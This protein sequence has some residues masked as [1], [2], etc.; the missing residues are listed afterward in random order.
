MTKVLKILGDSFK[1]Y[2]ASGTNTFVDNGIINK[3]SADNIKE[4]ISNFAN[5]KLK[6]FVYNKH[7]SDMSEEREP[8]GEVLS[9]SAC[10]DSV[11]LLANIYFNDNGE[12]LLKKGG[13]YPSIEMSGILESFNDNIRTWSNCML[14]ALACVEYPASSNV[15]LLCMSGVIE[16]QNN[17]EL[18][19][20][21]NKLEEL[22]QQVASGNKDVLPELLELLKQDDT[23]LGEIVMKAVTPT[24]TAEPT[25]QTTETETTKVEENPDGTVTETKT[26]VTEPT[27]EEK[28]K[29]EEQSLSMTEWKNACTKYAQR[30]GAIEVAMSGVENT[31]NRAKRMYK[32][33]E[34]I[35]N[36]IDYFKSNFSLLGEVRK[37]KA[38]IDLSAI[39]DDEIYERIGASIR[40]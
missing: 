38:N 4:L 9:L 5:N 19:N 18:E 11:G 39:K 13:F 23:L 17:K 26:E 8:I 30:N 3:I 28:K 15:D 21:D 32:S 20:M 36:I 6:V 37:E 10:D 24:A 22:M 12:K 7:K 34:S 40:R 33:G 1:H 25:T 2:T 29:E 31:Y 27:D 14:K 16:Y 35:D